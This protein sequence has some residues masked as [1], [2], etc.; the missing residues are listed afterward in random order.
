[1][2]MLERVDSTIF[3]DA[4]IVPKFLGTGLYL[5]GLCSKPVE[6]QSTRYRCRGHIM[7][8]GAQIDHFVLDIVRTRLGMADVP[9][10]LPRQDE[11]RIR[12]IKYETDHHRAETIRSQRDYDEIIDLG[13][14]QR[15]E[16]L[17]SAFDNLALGAQGAVIDVLCEVRLYPHPRG[18]KRFDPDTVQVNWR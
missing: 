10:L 12:A 16:N 15:A 4:H 2:T 1:M 14:A 6:T 9:N 5:C 13:L 11:P 7:R 3:E 18:V 17:A 8:S